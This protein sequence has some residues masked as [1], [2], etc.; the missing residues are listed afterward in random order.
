VLWRSALG[1]ARLSEFRRRAEHPDV[2]TRVEADWRNGRSE[3]SLHLQ[4]RV[5]RECD[6]H[7]RAR[8]CGGCR[9]S[10][11]TE[12]SWEVKGLQQ[13]CRTRFEGQ[14]V[15]TKSNGALL[16]VSAGVSKSL[17]A[18]TSSTA[19]RWRPKPCF[20]RTSRHSLQLVVVSSGDPQFKGRV[21][22]CCGVWGDG[23]IAFSQ[24][25][26]HFWV[27]DALYELEIF[28]RSA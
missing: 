17:R 24:T 10:G 9:R 27:R 2:R 28:P 20:Q 1:R 18:E 3:H 25:M 13:I 5:A 26:I 15:I 8:G 4:I 11:G 22:R 21:C 19:Q 7:L 14:P 12:K 23:R 16:V 6:F